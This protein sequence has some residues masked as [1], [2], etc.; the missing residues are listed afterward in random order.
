MLYL[1]FYILVGPLFI[2]FRH[3]YNFAITLRNNIILCDFPWECATKPSKYKSNLPKKSV[4]Y[5]LLLLL[6]LL[7][8]LTK[9]YSMY[10]VLTCSTN[11]F[12]LSPFGTTFFQLRTF[13]LFLSSKTSSFQRV[14]G[15]PI[16]LLDMGFHLLI[17]CTLLSSVMRST[18]PSQL[19]FCFLMNPII[20]CPFNIRILLYLKIFCS[21]TCCSDKTQNKLLCEHH[22]KWRLYWTDEARN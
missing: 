11:F 19:S 16:G 18:W 5:C 12:Q 7:L 1:Q 22:T 8:L 20:F 9:R 10:K 4:F 14:L 3:K 6:L 13:M 2:Y 21:M 15:L 17:F